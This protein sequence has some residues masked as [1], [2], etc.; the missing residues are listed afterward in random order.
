M[1]AQDLQKK[2]RTCRRFGTALFNAAVSVGIDDKVPQTLAEFDLV[3]R[4]QT[5]TDPEEPSEMSIPSQPYTRDRKADSCHQ[6]GLGHLFCDTVFTPF[7]AHAGPTGHQGRHQRG[8]GLFAAKA[9][10]RVKGRPCWR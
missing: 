7:T 6:P 8:G 10:G 3:Q 4:F 2:T 1:Q 5:P 9:P